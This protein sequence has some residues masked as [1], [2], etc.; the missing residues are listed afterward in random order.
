[1]YVLSGTKE[2]TWN[3]NLAFFFGIKLANSNR[4][5]PPVGNFAHSAVVVLCVNLEI[6]C[7]GKDV[8]N[9]GQ[10]KTNRPLW[11]LP[12]VPG[13]QRSNSRLSNVSS[14]VENYMG[15][16][17]KEGRIFNDRILSAQL[18]SSSRRRG[19]E[20]RSSWITI[21]S[22]RGRGSWRKHGRHAKQ[23]LSTI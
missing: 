1:M 7:V 9:Q 11:N 3:W 13:A 4:P 22:M 20:Y 18:R 2:L 23:F 12:M 5:N 14:C 6:G 17:G 16:K 15:Q 19:R 10:K 21:R 8:L